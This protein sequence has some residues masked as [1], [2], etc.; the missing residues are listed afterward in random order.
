MKDIAKSGFSLKHILLIDSN[1]HR[2][3]TVSFDSNVENNLNIN[4]GVNVEGRTVNVMLQVLV[5]QSFEKKYKL[6][7]MSK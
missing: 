4:T 5:E 1:F 7:L 6:K 3:D 2:E